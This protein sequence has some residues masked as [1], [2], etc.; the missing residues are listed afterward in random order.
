MAKPKKRQR[1]K[2]LALYEPG[3][4]SY[5]SLA[6]QLKVTESTIRRWVDPVSREKLLACSREA[7]ARR[8]GICADCGGPTRYNGRQRQPRRPKTAVSIR[9]AACSLARLNSP[10]AIAERTVWSQEKI[11]E[12]IQ[13]W[14]AEHGDSPRATDFVGKPDY[15]ALTTVIR[16]FG[17]W[18]HAIEAA[19]YEPR[20]PTDRLV[21]LAGERKKGE[22]H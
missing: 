18:N 13:K 2:A 10:Q 22:D 6:R 4:T 21:A 12:A 16:Y 8:T 1:E 11:V 14:G 15:P 9:C 17:S 7:K 5:R 19:G 3:V 20:L